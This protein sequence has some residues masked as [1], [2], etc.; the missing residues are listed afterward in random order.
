MAMRSSQ[1]V[2]PLGFRIPAGSRSSGASQSSVPGLALFVLL[3][4]VRVEVAKLQGRPATFPSTPY[5][6]ISPAQ[7]YPAPPL[8]DS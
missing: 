7:Y 8:A 6:S 4:R 3:P 2:L 5:L 1:G